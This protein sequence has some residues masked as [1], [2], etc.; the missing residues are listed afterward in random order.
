M[1]CSRIDAGQR[2][3]V[4]A[5]QAHDAAPAPSRP[6]RSASARQLAGGV[7]TSRK[8]APRAAVCGRARHLLQVLGVRADVAD[9]RE[10]EGHDLGHVGGVGQDLLVA[11]HGGV[12]ADLAHR[13]ADRAD[14]DALQH[15]PVGERQH[16]GAAGHRT[17]HG[18]LLVGKR[19]RR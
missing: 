7:G 6:C 8:I 5:G 11:G 4:D 18:R 2:A 13:L 10:G 3:G 15:R 1:P 9:V 17:A 12:E 16:A 19:P 14:A